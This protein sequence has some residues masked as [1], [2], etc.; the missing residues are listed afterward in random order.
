[1][2]IGL[3]AAATRGCFALP[4]GP[5]S[6][7]PRLTP[8]LKGELLVLCGHQC[9]VSFDIDRHLGFDL[10]RERAMRR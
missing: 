8:R 2:L 10:R 3:C 1:M 7:L 5:L 6:L 9:W 4:L